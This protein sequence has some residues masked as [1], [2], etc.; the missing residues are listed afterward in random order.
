MTNFLHVFLHMSKT[1]RLCDPPAGGSLRFHINIFMHLP[2][3]ITN[4]HQKLSTKFLKKTIKTFHKK[5]NRTVFF[6]TIVMF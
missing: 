4:T 5:C 2:N 1:I 6:I 3:I